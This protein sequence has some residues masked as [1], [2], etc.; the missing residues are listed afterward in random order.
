[1]TNVKWPI[2]KFS[3]LAF[4]IYHLSETIMR[5]AIYNPYLDTLGGGERYVM[6]IASTLKNNG[7]DVELA[8]HNSKII[9]WLEERLGIDLDGIEI[10]PDISRGAGYDLVF[11]LSDGSIPTLFGKKNIL[12]F[13]TPFHNIGGKSLFNKLKLL[14]IGRVVCNSQ[15]TKGFIDKEYGVNSVIV[16]PPVMVDEFKPRKKENLILSVG[17]FSQLQQSK[18]QDI[19]VQT[20]KKMLDKGLKGWKLVLIGGSDV[21]GGKF[22]EYLREEAKGFPIEILEN[23]PF[24]EVKKFYSKAKIFWSAAGYGIDE[25]KEPEKVEHFGITVVEAMAAGCVPIVTNKGGHKEIV[26]EGEDG[27]LWQEIDGLVKKTTDLA[28]DNGV[29]IKLAKKGQENAQRFSEKRFQEEILKL[30]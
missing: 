14:K 5:A 3:P 16:Y 15:F 12:H 18:R 9:K 8:W 13:Q 11:W 26:S 6:T 1:M 28:K 19:L 23:L 10:V 29:R 27:F 20:F 7:W 25:G 2:K 21:G 30:V 17:R 4:G 22:A 24:S